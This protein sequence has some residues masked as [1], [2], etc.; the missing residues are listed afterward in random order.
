[1]AVGNSR[2]SAPWSTSALLHSGNHCRAHC[3]CGRNRQF[4]CACNGMDRNDA[5]ARACA[6]THLVPANPHADLAV[7][8]VENLESRIARR[9]VRLLL[10]AWALGDVRFSIKAQTCPGRIDDANRIVVRFGDGSAAVRACVRERKISPCARIAYRDRLYLGWRARRSSQPP[11]S[12]SA[13]RSARRYPGARSPR[14]SMRARTDPRRRSAEST[15]MRKA[16]ASTE[17]PRRAR[18]PATPACRLG[19]CYPRRRSRNA[20]APHRR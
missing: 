14:N 18:S 5:R 15:A 13:A 17:S 11:P 12:S 8:R 9:E 4:R 7:R 3:G 2:T 16:P 6:A 1:M 10:V 20:S 19:R